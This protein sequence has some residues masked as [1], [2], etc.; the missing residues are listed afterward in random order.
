MMKD[1]PVI[2]GKF[3]S[4]RVWING[5]ELRPA[6]S[7]KLFSHSPEGF[8]WG[9]AGSGPAQLALAILL[10]LLGDKDAETAVAWHQDFKAGFIQRLPQLDFQVALP[11]IWTIRI[12]Q[13]KN[14]R[15]GR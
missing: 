2:R 14:R 10:E 1:K 12:L 6:K 15:I 4:R 5:K 7:L 3:Q 9:Y 11:T 8:N 13:H